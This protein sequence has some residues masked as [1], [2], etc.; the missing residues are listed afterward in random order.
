[1]ATIAA[2]VGA[3]LSL[4]GPL[5]TAVTQLISLS[6]QMPAVTNLLGGASPSG[7]SN[8]VLNIGVGM[9]EGGS[10]DNFGG[11]G[12]KINTFTGQGTFIS[13]GQAPHMNQGQT[14]GVPLDASKST[15]GNVQAWQLTISASG[16]DAVCVQYVELGWMGTLTSGFDGTWGKDCG[17]DWYWSESTW[18]SIES[19][20]GSTPLPYRPACWWM[21]NVSKEHKTQS[22]PNQEVWV[23][24]ELLL[25]GAP[26]FAPGNLTATYCSDQVTRFSST[27]VGSKSNSVPGGLN[28]DRL[29]NGP[30]GGSAPTVTPTVR[31][32][33]EPH[34]PRTSMGKRFP[35]AGT[36]ESNHGTTQAQLV[37][38]DIESHSAQELCDHPQSRG[39]DFV[40]KVE[41]LFCDMSAKKTYPLCEATITTNCF[42]LDQAGKRVRKRGGDETG[43][44]DIDH[45]D[46]N[47]V[48][49]WT[50]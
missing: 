38:S 50:G 12:L 40:S 1:M 9:F 6:S 49:T 42:A 44:G 43:E 29:G 31:K 48:S 32:R 27:T 41:N 20:D 11:D 18:G 2:T 13:S 23:N 17:Q 35:E 14:F 5:N 3:F 4:V 10:Q 34:H 19:S 36:L 46:Y 25:T 15:V 16:A 22:H 39:P 30:P 47:T 21:D 24:M 8:T 45:R 37:V 28:Q 33:A 7:E 26:L